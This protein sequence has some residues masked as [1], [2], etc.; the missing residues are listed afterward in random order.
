MLCSLLKP[1]NCICYQ[2][3]DGEQALQQFEQNRFDLIFTDIGLPTISRLEVA[4]L[5]RE[6]KLFLG[7]HTPIV[8]LSSF[9][10]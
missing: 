3:F 6:K 10:K 7:Y 2:A 1:T 8:V 4:K 5:I 9:K